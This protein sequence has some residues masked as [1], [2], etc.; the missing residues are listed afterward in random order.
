M[1]SPSTPNVFAKDTDGF[2]A[3]NFDRHISGAIS[4][5]LMKTPVTPNQMY[6]G[7]CVAGVSLTWMCLRI[8][9]DPATATT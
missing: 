5:Q 1:T 4:R 9:T 8:D 2:F 7:I 3:R 6:Y